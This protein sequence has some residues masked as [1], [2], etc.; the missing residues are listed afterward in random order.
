MLVERP[1]TG[2]AI[3]ISGA[4]QP[5]LVHSGSQTI[6][7]VADSK[8]SLFLA[9]LENGELTLERSSGPAIKSSGPS[10]PIKQWRE[11]LLTLDLERGVL[12]FSW[13]SPCDTPFIGAEGLSLD[14]EP[15]STAHVSTLTFGARKVIKKGHQRIVADP[16]NGRIADLQ[17]FEGA[18]DL[19][20]L[21][22]SWD[23]RTSCAARPVSAWDFAAVAASETVPD[24]VGQT[25]GVTINRPTRL[26]AGPRFAGQ[27]MSASQAPEYFNAA[28]FHD[29]DL[30]DAGWTEGF[31]FTPPSDLP[32]G[33]YAFRLISAEGE[34][35]VPFFVTAVPGRESAP[36]AVLMPTLSYQ[37]Y[38]DIGT[39]HEFVAGL[40]KAF[41][42]L[43]NSTLP[44]TEIEAYV[45]ENL[46]RSCYD[47]H[48][49]GTGVC[50]ATSLRPMLTNVRPS[51]INRLNNSPHQLSSDL[52]LVDWLHEK[53]IPFE[54]ITDHDLHVRGVDAMLPYRAVISG[55]HAEYWTS[56]MLDALKGYTDSGG[57]FV[58]LSGN[59]LYWATALSADGTLCEVRRD[60]GT[61]AWSS[62]SHEKVLS[63]SG[64][65]G[66]IWRD[67]GRAPQR[68]VGTGFISQG[69]D[70]GRPYKRM[71]DSHNPRVSF[72]FEGV[73]GELIGDFASLVNK[74][75]AAGTEF[76]RADTGL[77]TPEH[78][79]L[80]ARASGFSNAYQLA[81]EEVAMNSPYDGGSQNPNV[82]SD[83]LFYETPHNGAVFS[84]P[85]MSWTSALSFNNY[86]NNVARITENVVRSFVSIE[87][88]HASK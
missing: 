78:A 25:H 30:N 26:V 86:D 23:N 6:L 21:R 27:V 87:W 12:S 43:M 7:S 69:G 62:A 40:D 2:S 85:S 46:L 66:G 50:L 11:F 42:P 70:V 8:G 74:H 75:G 52:C 49:D 59:S 64:T 33:V 53:Q 82:Y 29:D 60:N 47:L 41:V 37:V 19:A 18:E 54:V 35:R 44:E 28:H 45:R 48:S 9:R 32:S 39:D 81:V 58:H 20:K 55:S 83:M 88:Q 36:L 71:P 31:R 56:E 14:F 3:A 79:L 80:L 16:F 22:S 72:I 61:R 63:L 34:D 38:A 51:S 57:R 84:A 17:L 15:D 68:Y 24:V 73:E 65:P 67:Q 10:L 76:D 13:R 77:G 4:F 5:T 1:S